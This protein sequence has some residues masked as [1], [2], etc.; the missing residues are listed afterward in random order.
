MHHVSTERLLLAA[1]KKEQLNIAEQRHLFDCEECR[2]LMTMFARQNL[3]RVED[4]RPL[5]DQKADVA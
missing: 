5:D 1:I 2:D 4:D 3:I